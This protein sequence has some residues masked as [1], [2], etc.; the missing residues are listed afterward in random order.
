MQPLVSCNA[1]ILLKIMKKKI[2]KITLL[3]IAI[4]IVIPLTKNLLLYFKYNHGNKVMTRIEGNQKQFIGKW[5]FNFDTIY[6][7]LDENHQFIFNIDTDSTAKMHYKFLNEKIDGYG[8]EVYSWRSL[9]PF[10][11]SKARE[12]NYNVRIKET[13]FICIPID[14]QNEDTLL[15]HFKF[16]NDSLYIRDTYLE[17]TDNNDWGMSYSFKA[18]FSTI[19][20]IRYVFQDWYSLFK[21]II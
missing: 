14:T 9:L 2:L 10:D 12:M 18:D 13:A 19:I 20:D 15:L 16:V 8:T 4:I 21:E 3:V 1:V 17:K 7:G 6:C 5:E 11:N